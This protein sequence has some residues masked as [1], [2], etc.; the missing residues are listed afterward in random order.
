VVCPCVGLCNHRNEEAQTRKGCKYQI[1]EEEEEEEIQEVNCWNEV[2]N[3]VTDLLSFF[4][5]TLSTV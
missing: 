3:H 4:F 5:F 1:E 2:R